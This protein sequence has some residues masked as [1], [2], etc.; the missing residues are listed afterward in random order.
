V[1]A[2]DEN[3]A[4]EK[5]FF[6][7]DCCNS[8]GM[9]D[10]AQKYKT[11]NFVAL[12]SVVPKDLSTG[13]WTFSNVL[14][15]GLLGKNFIDTDN[16]GSLTLI[17]LAQYIDQEMAI[18]E[19]QKAAY[20]VPQN[21]KNLVITNGI[22]KRKDKRI[23]EYVWVDYDGEDYLGFITASD[24]TKGLNVRFYSYTNNELDWV[25][26]NRTKPFKCKSD[27]SVGALVSV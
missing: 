18:V 23:G 9:A 16:N 12:N 2:V 22:A 13:N 19:G 4:G 3:F 21:L 11:K 17:E 20:Y 25:A 10:E 27:F 24:A 26:A 7:V 5:A 14:L 1:K 15:Y 6:V 8:G